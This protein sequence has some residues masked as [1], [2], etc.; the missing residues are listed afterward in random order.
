MNEKIDSNTAQ[1]PPTAGS[2]KKGDP[3][4]NRNGQIS[5][6]VLT[7][8]RTLRDLLITEGEEMETGKI[9]EKTLHLK[10][11]LWLI[12]SVWRAAIAGEAWA[13]NFIAERT[14]GKI[15]QPIIEE[16]GPMQELKEFLDEYGITGVK[17]FVAILRNGNGDGHRRL[18]ELPIQPEDSEG[19][20]RGPEA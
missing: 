1:R 15:S 5:H 19:D 10:R 7:F 17:E 14:E 4:I 2:F 3:R 20:D 12:K 16:I 11:V 13:V 6:K 18:L 9:G 8:N